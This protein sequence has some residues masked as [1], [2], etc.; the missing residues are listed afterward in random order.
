MSHIAV[1][2]GFRR[3]KLVASGSMVCWMLWNQRLLADDTL[4]VS[5]VS[6]EKR[7]ICS[8]RPLR[9]ALVVESQVCPI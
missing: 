3:G 2:Y 7:D 1:M 4:I 8:I 5:L 6:A 9:P